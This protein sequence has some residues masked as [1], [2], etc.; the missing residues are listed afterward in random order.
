M[1]SYPC[2]EFFCKN[3]LHFAFSTPSEWVQ[4]PDKPCVQS[5][6]RMKMLWSLTLLCIS[7]PQ[8]WAL[9]TCTEARV[10]ISNTHTVGLDNLGSGLLNYTWTFFY[11]HNFIFSLASIF[12]WTFL[13]PLLSFLPKT[14]ITAYLSWNLQLGQIRY[15][16]THIKLLH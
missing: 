6:N 5:M 4:Q 9:F 15:Y 7:L 14:T 10:F 3:I 8:S 16:G 11:R 2:S 12:K 13:L 1:I